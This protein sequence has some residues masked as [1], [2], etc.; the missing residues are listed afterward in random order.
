MPAQVVC[1]ENCAGIKPARC[2]VDAE[3]EDI[4]T[5]IADAYLTIGC[6]VMAP[7]RRRF[8]MIPALIEEF[9]ADAVLDITLSSCHTYLIE[10][11]SLRELCRSLGVPY[12]ALETD[13]SQ[14]DAGQIDTRIAAFVESL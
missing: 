14:L 8:D 4:L 11:R 6:A 12:M 9:H 7:N 13:Y 3:A 10:G 5:A 2:C 1:F